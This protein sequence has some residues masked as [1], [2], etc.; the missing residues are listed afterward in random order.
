[1]WKGHAKEIVF[2]SRIGAALSFLYSS[3]PVMP[4][5]CSSNGIYGIVLIVF[6][7][8]RIKCSPAVPEFLEACKGFNEKHC[9]NSF[10]INPE[11]MIIVMQQSS[12]KLN[13]EFSLGL[14]KAK[15]L[16]LSPAKTTR[17]GV[18]SILSW[19]ILSVFNLFQSYAFLFFSG[20][21]TDHP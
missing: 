14:S 16:L 6:F 3:K 19:M 10:S 20:F 5:R 18:L 21:Y 2:N 4:G 9:I 12:L 11:M 7:C 17:T 1:M 15:K 8:I 13:V